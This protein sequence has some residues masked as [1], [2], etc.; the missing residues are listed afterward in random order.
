MKASNTQPKTVIAL[1]AAMLSLIVALNAFVIVEPGQVGVVTHFGAVQSDILGEGL[2]LITPMRTKIISMDTRVQKLEA[3]ASASSKDLQVVTSKVA[4][5]YFLDKTKANEIF[6]SLGLNYRS[7]IVEPTIQETVKSATAQ[8][9]AEQLITRRPEVKD[10]I[11]QDLRDRLKRS[12]I[13]VTDFSILDFSFSREFNRAIEEKQVAE[14]AA[15]RARN[16]LT[17]I[18]TEA[19][20]VTAK[21]KGEAEARLALAKAEAEAQRMLAETI[22]DRLLQLRAIE[23]WDGVMPVALG[24]GA[25]GTF[26][27]VLG[28]ARLQAAARDASAARSK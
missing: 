12:N 4:L 16:D 28:A 9:T 27:D 7:S 17:R 23:K 14:Q 8:F 20:Q 19:E 26:I 2:H 15:L 11:F 22:D 21:A 24:D 1:I 3:E 13:I 5:N 6:Q 25:N 10:R 18:T